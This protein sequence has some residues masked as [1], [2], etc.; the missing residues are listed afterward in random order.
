[1]AVSTILNPL[2]LQCLSSDTYPI[3]E[4]GSTLHIVDTGDVYVCHDGEW[5]ID[6][7]LAR[8]LLLKDTL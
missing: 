2:S 6:L 7:R 5:S 3:A 8:A 4:N 1:M